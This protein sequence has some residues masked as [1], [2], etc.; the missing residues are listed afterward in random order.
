MNIADITCLI[1]ANADDLG[2]D[3]YSDRFEWIADG[4]SRL[5]VTSLNE[6]GL[7]VNRRNH[8]LVNGFAEIAV[9]FMLAQRKHAMVTRGVAMMREVMTA[10]TPKPPPNNNGDQLAA[11]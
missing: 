7:E 8:D 4:L 9:N 5:I 10:T 3:E 2:S 1:A 6:R 11:E